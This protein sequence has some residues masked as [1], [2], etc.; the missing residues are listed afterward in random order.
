MNIHTQEEIFPTLS[1][2]NDKHSEAP[3][4]VLEVLISLCPYWKSILHS[5][6]DF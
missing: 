3:L 4:Q 1:Y 6:L 2:P 5:S